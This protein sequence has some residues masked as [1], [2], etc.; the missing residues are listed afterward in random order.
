MEELSRILKIE[1]RVHLPGLSN[2]LFDEFYRGKIFAVTS[3]Y[4]PFGMALAEAMS[5]GMPAVSFDLPG[6]PRQIVRHEIDGLLVPAG[7]APAFAAALERL[8]DNEH[9]RQRLAGRAVE[10][11]E[12]FGLP[13][14]LARWDDLF[15]QIAPNSFPP[16][17][18]SAKDPG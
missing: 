4:E 15:A 5:C 12:R 1:D 2:R 17:M 10:A 3:R 9:L 11:A 7:D 13:Q 18:R 14:I 6:G 8:M 16:S